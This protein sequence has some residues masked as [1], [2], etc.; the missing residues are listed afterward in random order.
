M[1][2][3]AFNY[4]QRKVLKSGENFG[5]YILSGMIWREPQG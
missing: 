1:K 2:I 4:L 5:N 3:S